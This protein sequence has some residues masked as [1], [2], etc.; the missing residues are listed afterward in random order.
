M[1][2]SAQGR[3]QGLAHSFT[4]VR[5]QRFT[6]GFTLI[7]LLVA[8][9]VLALLAVF[10]WRGLDQIVRTRETLQQSQQALDAVQRLFAN[11]ARD[12]A[13]A[14]RVRVD[15]AGHIT[16][17]MPPPEP[18]AGQEGSGGPAQ[19][20]TLPPVEYLL[21]GNRLVRR[22]G[23]LAIEQRLLD[24]VAEWNGAVR[25][26]NGNWGV[27]PDSDAMPTGLRVTMRVGT[28]GAVSRIFLL[29]D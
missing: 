26:A 21:D 10:A 5:A 13:V 17:L 9:S 28:D 23:I 20:Q 1:R 24:N 7:E 19:E 16:F 3:A 8:I 4:Q 25:L 22:D 6:Q 12:V 15:G 18:V 11:L 29:R 2:R 14:R 27:S